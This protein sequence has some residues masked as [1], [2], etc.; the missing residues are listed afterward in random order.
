MYDFDPVDMYDYYHDDDPY[1]MRRRVLPPRAPHSSRRR[2]THYI[3]EDILEG[4]G[5]D[6]LMHRLLQDL[7]IHD[8]HSSKRAIEYLEQH[9]Q[10]DTLALKD[11]VKK[12]KDLEKAS[13]QIKKTQEAM[14]SERTKIHDLLEQLINKMNK[15]KTN[16]EKKA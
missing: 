10:K 4:L 1:F 7:H 16:G 5:Q 11:L 12:A 13:T 3:D 8:E 6:E 14:S 2:R 15:E 9:N